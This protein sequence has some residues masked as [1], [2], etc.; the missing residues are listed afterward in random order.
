MEATIEVTGLYKR[1]GP[2]VVLGGGA[3]TRGG[4]RRRR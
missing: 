3:A 2:T 4:R 1:F